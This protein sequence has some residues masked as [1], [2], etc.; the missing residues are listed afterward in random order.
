MSSLPERP[1]L[2]KDFSPRGGGIDFLGL[3]YVNLHIVGSDLIPELNNVTRDMGTFFVGAWIP[4]K[5]AQVCKKNQYTERNYCTYREKVEVALSLTM[6][7]QSAAS[8]EHGPVRNRVGITQ[9]CELP[10]EL[11][12]KN[13]KRSPENTLYA[14]A[15]YG[16][17][18]RALGL[19]ES[20][21]AQA[22]GGHTIDIAVAASD[23]DTETILESLDR[24]LAKQEAYRALT[25]LKS[26]EFTWEQI[27]ALGAA[28]LCPSASRSETFKAA[29]PCFQ[30]KLLPEDPQSLGYARTRTA[31]LLLAT[32]AQQAPLKIHDIRDTW[33]TGSF[34]DGSRFKL[35][36]DDLKDQRTR[37]SFFM[38]RQYQR[39]AIELFLWCFEVALRDG[40][41]SIDDAI[42]YWERRTRKE[43]LNFDGSFRDVMRS[44]AGGLHCV[45]DLD[46]S[47]KWN[48]TVHG[49]HEQMEYIEQPQNNAAGIS[50]LKM[51]AGWYWRM[52]AREND[53][54]HKDLMTLGQSD[55]MSMSWFLDWLR[56]RQ[57]MPVREMLKDIFSDL[58]FSQ[59]MRVALSRFDGNAQRLRFVLGDS[60]IEPTV[61]AKSDL[62]NRGLPWMPDRLDTL[63]ELMCD[64][65]VLKM[66]DQG[67]LELGPRSSTVSKT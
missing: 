23:P 17:A 39:Y 7:N 51:F 44:V 27:D 3:R 10:A 5:F 32:L 29:K 15:I 41:R 67:S 53:A 63:A 33:Y 38:A 19:I 26:Y 25:S 18:L 54:D 24:E 57:N 9:Q 45:D 47:A 21:R 35:K 1:F 61:S 66:N 62:G 64:I 2:T 8:M 31:R 48:T 14:A 60:G 6:R 22:E 28:G 58:V 13:A 20:Y 59:H 49:A 46:T 65:D 36:D 11:S 4:W 50:G 55:R 37:W 52:L 56:K 34:G 16:P 12:F 40:S 42:R 30:R 43:G